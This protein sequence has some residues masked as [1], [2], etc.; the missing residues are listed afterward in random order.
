MTE[1]SPR[2]ARLTAARALRAALAVLGTLAATAMLLASGP[3]NASRAASGHAAGQLRW[4]SVTPVRGVVDLAARADGSLVVAARGRLFT[5]HGASVRGFAPA[6][7]A[8]PGLEPYIVLSAGQAVPGA[9]C[10]FAAGDLFALRLAGGNGVTRV[11][12]SGAVSRFA[13]LPQAG[14]ENGIAFDT[15]GRFGHRLLVTR[16]DH[17]VTTVFAIDC[18]G[19]VAVVTRSAPRVEGG[20]VVAPSGFGRFGGELIAPDELTGR[21]E[22]IAPTGRATL[23]VTAGGPHGQDVGPESE[24]VVPGSYSQALVADRGTPGN[25]HPGDNLVLGLAASALGAAGVRPG[26]LLV[27]SEGAA[28]TIDLRCRTTCSTRE[29]ALGPREAHIEGHV[30]FVR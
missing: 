25:R 2:V 4:S 19:R 27:V 12:P 8:P 14:L 9:G 1:P 3:F 20:I 10:R 21:I 23:V 15:T 22:A 26:D 11:T 5:L 7:A 28:Q 30:A 13:R 24:G 6:Y 17:G 16:I 29:V 18:R